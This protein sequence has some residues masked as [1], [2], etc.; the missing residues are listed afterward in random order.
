M[1]RVRVLCIGLFGV[2]LAATA[3]VGHA[4]ARPLGAC[5]RPADAELIS[6]RP[7]ATES[8]AT[9]PARC[10]Q[11]EGGATWE[12]AEDD[13]SMTWGE[14]LLRY[15]VGDRWELRIGVPSYTDPGVGAAGFEDSSLGV[16]LL[17]ARHD[18]D[19]PRRPQAALLL[20]S[21]LPTGET[22]F[23][24][25]H[26][27]PAA[28]LALAWPL[29]ARTELATNLGA[30]YPSVEAEQFGTALASVAVGRELSDRLG[31]FI[32]LF[33]ASRDEPGGSARTFFDAGITWAATAD[34]QLDLRAGIALGP[35]DDEHFV[36][37]GL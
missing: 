27:Q 11:L 14:L 36:G 12:E 1:P 29:G 26:A 17:L 22:G 2:G 5:E 34:L 33:G 3:L 21:T 15:G 16:K 35:S 31:G 24:E 20:D 6:D 13:E 28:L 32:E 8:A 10:W 18:P 19:R 4:G 25:P 30:A 37:A 7:D 9:V 23:R